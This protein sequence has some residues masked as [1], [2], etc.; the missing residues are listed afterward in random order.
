MNFI[1]STKFS[2]YLAFGLLLILFGALVTFLGGCEQPVKPGETYHKVSA[3]WPLFDVEKSEGIEDDGTKWQKEKGDALF[4]L[5]TWEKE[6]R[7]DKDGFLIY[8]KERDGFFPIYT[9][10]IEEDKEFRTKKGAILVFPYYS[11]R[12]KTVE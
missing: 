7:Y 8:R 12:A 6:K 9:N 5:S 1:N 3:A 11:R 2:T 10:E 4:W